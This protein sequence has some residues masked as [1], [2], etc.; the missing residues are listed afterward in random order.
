MQ[1]S[2]ERDATS[3][4]DAGAVLADY[5]A[6][7]TYQ[8]LPPAVVATVK[9][10]LLDTLGVSYAA[11]T[12]SPGVKELVEVAQLSGRS[13]EGSLLGFGEAAP[14][15]F[16]A[17]ANGGMAHALNYDCS[18]PSGC[19]LG[20]TTIPAAL[21]AAEHIGNV[22]GEEFLAALAAGMEVLARIGVAVTNTE[23]GEINTKAPKPL[24]VQIWGYFSAAA[25]AGRVMNLPPNKMRSA[26]GLAL[27]QAAG[28]Y[29]PLL[30]ATPA[31][32][33]MAFPNLSGLLSALLSRQG[34][35]ADFAMFEGRAGFFAMFYNGQYF[36]PALTDE[37]GEKYY[38]LDVRFKPWPITGVAHTFIEAA[39]SLAR[40]HEIDPVAIE[41]VRLTG[42]P[43]ILHHCEPIPERRRPPDAASAA[44]SI[45]FG[46]AKALTNRELTLA[47]FT[48]EGLSQPGVLRLADRVEYVI[49]SSLGNSSI[50]EVST[51][52]G[53]VYAGRADSARGRSSDPLTYAEV[54][55]KFMD[56]TERVVDPLPRATREQLV[57]QI[58]HLESVEAVD[59]L[60]ALLRGAS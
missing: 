3:S 42:G 4:S 16:A 23:Y 1:G 15:L 41:R 6:T 8:D 54:V 26:L 35:R 29:Q 2:V 27:M 12:R 33:Y 10:I 28:S 59:E 49:D 40:T 14:A 9:M 11:S 39:L 7:L 60:V 18:T 37:L 58:N 22:S 21:A 34:L 19:H 38:L 31:K 24:R 20:A 36:R 55:D 46:V 25:S 30:E 47:D 48:P 53:Q 5:A 13:R 44:D 17:F 52:G 57:E 56:C 50:V 32:V 51:A 43:R 45:I